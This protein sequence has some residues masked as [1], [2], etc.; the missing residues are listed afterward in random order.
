MSV[1]CILTGQMPDVND[2][3]A[4]P[5]T[6]KINNKT[7][8]ADITITPDNIGAASKSI[9]KTLSLPVSNWNNNTVSIAAEVNHSSNV[10]VAAAPASHMAYAQAGVRCSHQ[11]PGVLT[12]VCENTPTEELMVNVLIVG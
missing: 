4:V 12:F 8:D 5:V 1:K 7:L 11:G 2:I 9:A 3:G 10:I 6:R